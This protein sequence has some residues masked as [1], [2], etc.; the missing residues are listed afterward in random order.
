MKTVDKTTVES[1]VAAYVQRHPELTYDA[2][3]HR[4]H[5]SKTAL[6]TIL[7]EAGV[8][9]RP[10]ATSAINLDELEK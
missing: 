5:I 7:K 6:T 10:A 4:L 1:Q 3:C 9:R 8:V 2:I